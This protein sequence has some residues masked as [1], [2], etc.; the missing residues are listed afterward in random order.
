[1]KV[2][3][4]EIDGL[5]LTQSVA[6][7][8][9]LADRWSIHQ[10]VSTNMMTKAKLPQQNETSLFNFCIPQFPWCWHHA[11]RS[12]NQG[13]GATG[14]KVFCS[15]KLFKSHHSYWSMLIIL[16]LSSPW[17]YT[18]VLQLVLKRYLSWS[19]V[20]SSQFKTSA[21]SRFLISISIVIDCHDQY[22][23]HITL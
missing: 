17:N 6:I 4:L 9:Y 23:I 19:A 8:E 18:N 2:P 5:V 20:A 22:D 16:L 12:Q 1:M 10:A 11:K 14:K 13:Q 7:M 3:C 15:K 21:S